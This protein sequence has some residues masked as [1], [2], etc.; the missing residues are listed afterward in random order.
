MIES[1][2][3]YSFKLNESYLF[4]MFAIAKLRCRSLFKAPDVHVLFLDW[5]VGPVV[6]GTDWV[7]FP[8]KCVIGTII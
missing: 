2:L 3:I 4:T 5:P 7:R 8:L 6:S 1:T